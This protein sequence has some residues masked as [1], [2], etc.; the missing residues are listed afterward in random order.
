MKIIIATAAFALVLIAAPAARRIA[1]DAPPSYENI[2]NDIA[3]AP[4]SVG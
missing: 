3:N 2:L 1:S 4:D